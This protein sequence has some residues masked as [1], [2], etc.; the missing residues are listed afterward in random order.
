MYVPNFEIKLYNNLYKKNNKKEQLKCINKFIHS[1]RNASAV[2]SL[3]SYN[4][5]SFTFIHEVHC[6]TQ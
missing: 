1:W 4:G 5:L 2:I 3:G 6:P